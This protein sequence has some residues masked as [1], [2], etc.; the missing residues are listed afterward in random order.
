MP[1]TWILTNRIAPVPRGKV[2]VVLSIASDDEAHD[3]QVRAD[4]IAKFR[5]LLTRDPHSGNFHLIVLPRYRAEQIVASADAR[6]ELAKIR[7]HFML[8]G[9]VRRRTIRDKESHVIAFEGLVRHAPIPPNVQRDLQ[10]DFTNVLPRRVAF[11]ADSDVFAF[12]ATA[13]WAD[14]SARYIIGLAALISGDVAYAERL[15]LD[16]EGR[17]AAGR[18]GFEPLR[19][20]SNRLPDRFRTLYEAWLRHLID[21]YTQTREEAYLRKADGI[22]GKLLV[23]DPRHHG[24]KLLKAMAEFS[25]RG[26][27]LGARNLVNQ[28]QVRGDVTWR[29]SLAFLDAYEGN[30]NAAEAEYYRAFTGPL[31]DVTVPIQCEE[32]IAGVLKKEPERI[33]LH[34]CSGLINYHAKKDCAGAVRDLTAF[35]DAPQSVRF[36]KQRE[37][38]EEIVRAC[39]AANADDAT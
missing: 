1:A 34:Y 8:Y 20:I 2:G 17:L 31:N 9:T 14:V 29:Y 37:V 26:N 38:A 21:R 10:A 39:A 19:Q 11:A 23:R 33:Q 5:D 6:N 36:P 7:A 13:E 25:L 3:R 35:L 24:A 22:A 28:C 16:V 18:R 27:V 32:F 30:L 15:F 4:F 12:E